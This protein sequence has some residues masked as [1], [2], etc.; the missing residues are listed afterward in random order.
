MRRTTMAAISTVAIAGALTFGTAYATQA[1]SDG[2]HADAAAAGST[3]SPVLNKNGHQVDEHAAK[4]QARAAAARA[5]HLAR[6]PASETPTPEP[7][8]AETAT[9]TPTPAPVPSD[10][11]DEKTDRDGRR[12]GDCPGKQ[13]DV[14]G[15]FDHRNHDGDHRGRSH[16]WGRGGGRDW[17][18]DHR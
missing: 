14:D 17:H 1:G 13:R 16:D 8:G 5:R 7:E 11:P 3:P 12:H 10:A 15:S 18:H 9:A 4:G 6:K 2:S